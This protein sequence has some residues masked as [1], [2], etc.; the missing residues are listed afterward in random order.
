M[1]HWGFVLNGT[2]W[3]S[4]TELYGATYIYIYVLKPTC[5]YFGKWCGS[6]D[7]AHTARCDQC[8]GLGSTKMEQTNVQFHF[9]CLFLL[10]GEA[11]SVT[12]AYVHC[13]PFVSTL[14]CSIFSLTCDLCLEHELSNSLFCTI[15]APDGCSFLALSSNLRFFGWSP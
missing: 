7:D 14:A 5:S 8:H 12:L 13:E 4:W 1:S 2:F 6:D 11:G 9:I 3:Y 15:L 10:E